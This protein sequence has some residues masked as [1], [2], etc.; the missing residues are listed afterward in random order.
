MPFTFLDCKTMMVIT[1]IK[2]FVSEVNFDTEFS[3][4][5]LYKF[6]HLVQQKTHIDCYQTVQSCIIFEHLPSHCC[7]F[8]FILMWCSDVCARQCGT[9]GKI[10]ITSVQVYHSFFTCIFIHM[11]LCG[12]CSVSGCVFLCKSVS[13]CFRVESN[14]HMLVWGSAQSFI[15]PLFP[16]THFQPRWWAVLP[17]LPHTA[18]LGRS[19]QHSWGAL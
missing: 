7:I 17:N 14:Q 9:C 16:S 8:M 19:W 13:A 10:C 6:S 1:S 4:T 5:L 11:C 15:I 3:I 2:K 18:C 12:V